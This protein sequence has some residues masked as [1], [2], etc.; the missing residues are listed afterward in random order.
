MTEQPIKDLDFHP[1]ALARCDRC[2]QAAAARLDTEHGPLFF[3]GH[4]AKPVERD[5]RVTFATVTA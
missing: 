5:P 1:I 2:N 4:H 3:C